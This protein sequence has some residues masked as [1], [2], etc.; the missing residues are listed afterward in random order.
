MTPVS[1]E[2]LMAF[3]DGALDDAEMA[4][5]AQA[6]SNE[7]LLAQKLER[8]MQT[9][10]LLRAA[11]D[12]PMHEVVPQ[13]LLDAV[14]S[15]PDYAALQARA[16]NENSR[17]LRWVALAATLL[18][19]AVLGS[20]FSNPIKQQAQTDKTILASAAMQNALENSASLQ[21][22]ALESGESLTPQ[23]S[24][25]RDDKRFCRQF[26]LRKNDTDQ[27]GIACRGTKGW[28]IAALMPAH[29]AEPTTGGYAAAASESDAALDEFMTRLGARD[30]LDAL[31]EKKLIAKAWR[32]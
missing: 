26:V 6:V 7:P 11:Y 20:Q 4:V 30:P 29:A 32:E 18:V 21:K 28:S 31:A 9:N 17:W 12:G 27:Q 5:V 23:L 10:A 24:F 1:D 14:R 16:A 3:A 2:T 15:A 19:G 25:Q 8:M 22:V 13:S